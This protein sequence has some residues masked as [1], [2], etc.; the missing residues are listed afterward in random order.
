MFIV[1]S[2]STDRYFHCYFDLPILIK[3][4]QFDASGI[5]ILKYLLSLKH[6]IP[7]KI[8]FT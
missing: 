2:T 3:L 1:I 7:N 4:L 6:N 8:V 5:P